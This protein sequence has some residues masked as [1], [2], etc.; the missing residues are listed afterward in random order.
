MSFLPCASAGLVFKARA[1]DDYQ[2]GPDSKPQDGVPKGTVQKFTLSG[3]KIFP[4]TEHTY[5]IYVPAQYD[6][7]RPACLYVNQDGIQNDAP[8]VFDNLIAHKEMPIT[9]GVFVTPGIVRAPSTN[10]L[11]R[12]NRSFEYDGL[13]PNYVRF[14]ADELLPEVER[15]TTEDGRAIHL[16][17]HSADRAIGGSSSGAICAFTAAWER[18]EEFSRVFSSI[19][20]YVGLRGGQIYPTLIR[21]FEPKPIGVFLQDGTNDLNIYAGDWWMANQTMERALV[22]SGY[23]VDHVWG[24]GGHNGK[25]AGAVFPDAMRFLWRD[26]PHLSEPAKPKTLI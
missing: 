4:G 6:P 5:W 13:G 15:K 21:K 1:A 24:E 12:F 10:Q 26:W 17:R 9:I 22:F 14:L 3:S 11:D 16:S 23:E 2:P 19:G 8:V 25:Q 20:T 18:P 7:A